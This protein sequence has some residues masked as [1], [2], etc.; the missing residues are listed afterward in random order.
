MWQ[1]AERYGSYPN[2]WL[3][4]DHVVISAISFLSL[5]KSPKHPDNNL[6]VRLR[7]PCA[8]GIGRPK[9][10]REESLTE[11]LGWKSWDMKIKTE[12]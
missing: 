5:E 7:L 9:M 11:K 4:K 10:G 12:S 3:V 2:S 8:I 1:L 6:K